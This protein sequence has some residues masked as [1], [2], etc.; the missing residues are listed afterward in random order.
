MESRAKARKSLANFVEQQTM[1]MPYFPATIKEGTVDKAKHTCTVEDFEGNEHSNVRLKA[2]I[3]SDKGF[4]LY[5]KDNSVVMVGRMK[6]DDSDLYVAL[7]GEIESIEI[8]ATA[9]IVFNQGENGGLTITPELKKQLEKLTARVDG[10]IDA[11]K[12][13]K[14]AT[15]QS[16]AALLTSF[17]AGVTSIV[18]KEDFSAIENE[19]IKH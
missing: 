2:T 17:I 9:T 6:K 16:G 12:N 8:D 10:I 3:D 18:D 11:I 15:D 7:F 4:V 5:P 19:K 13:G 1:G 14:V